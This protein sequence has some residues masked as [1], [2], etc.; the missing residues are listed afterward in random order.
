M[1]MTSLAAVSMSVPVPASAAPVV[2]DLPMPDW[3]YGAATL[4]VFLL[5]LGLI[6]MFRNV[7]HV[8]MYGRDGFPT[9]SSG[10][11]PRP[12]PGE[13]DQGHGHGAHAAHGAGH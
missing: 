3:A 4:A 1:S 12:E 13:H 5:L 2:W 7:A 11:G 9:T 8:L 6:W 10:R